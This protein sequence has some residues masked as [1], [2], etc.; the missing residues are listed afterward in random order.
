MVDLLEIFVLR[1]TKFHGGS[2]GNFR[3][4]GNRIFRLNQ[5]VIFVPRGTKFHGGSVGIF[6]SP[7]NVFR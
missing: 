2:V 5:P 7:G 3:S 4:P 1:G 6:R